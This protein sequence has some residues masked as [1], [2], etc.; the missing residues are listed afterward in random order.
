MPRFRK[1]KPLGV[2]DVCGAYIGIKMYLN[3]RCQQ[4]RYGRRCPG[5][6]KSDLG[7]VWNE[8]QSCRATGVLGGG[9]CPDCGGWGW[10]LLE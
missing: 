8:C 2:C 4:S 3:H 10:S 1:R 5:K 6:Y 9:A 7:H